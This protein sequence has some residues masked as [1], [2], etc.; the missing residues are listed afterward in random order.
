M[1]EWQNRPLDKVYPILIM[2]RVS[3]KG[4]ETATTFKTNPSI[5]L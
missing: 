1:I 3:R 2:E 5:W 4:E